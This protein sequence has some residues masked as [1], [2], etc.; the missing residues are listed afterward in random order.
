[1]KHVYDKKG[2]TQSGD[3]LN[4]EPKTPQ[5]LQNQMK[6][7]ET[8]NSF[9]TQSKDLKTFLSSQFLI[10][11]NLNEISL[12]SRLKMRSGSMESS[13]GASSVE[14]QQTIIAR[15]DILCAVLSANNDF[16]ICWIRLTRF[17]KKMCLNFMIMNKL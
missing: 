2:S 10:Q 15:I 17:K 1:M 13:D 6:T 3:N 16:S 14:T 7:K 11:T 8:T 9:K 12:K 5:K 4:Q